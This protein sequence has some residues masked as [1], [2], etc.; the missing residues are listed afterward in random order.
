M[1]H[2]VK[3][4]GIL[5]RCLAGG[6][7]STEILRWLD[8]QGALT[9]AKSPTAVV[10]SRLT[11]LNRDLK[12]SSHRRAQ[13]AAPQGVHSLTT[14][15]VD[16]TP[17]TPRLLQDLDRTDYDRFVRFISNTLP[18]LPDPSTL[19][20]SRQMRSRYKLCA[21]AVEAACWRTVADTDTDA[22]QVYLLQLW[23]HETDPTHC[24]VPV[25]ASQVRRW[26]D[27]IVDMPTD[28][29]SSRYFDLMH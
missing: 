9:G 1:K 18:V 29:I 3:G 19:G 7:T 10:V 12:R 27:S 15:D 2:P 25:V 24:P 5:K 6:M 14:V 11:R 22:D 21:A 23:A 13:Q 26:D 4:V 16:V 8:V 20:L 17:T 28:T